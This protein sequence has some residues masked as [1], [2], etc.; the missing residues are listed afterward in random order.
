MKKKTLLLDIDEVINDLKE[1]WIDLYNKKYNDNLNYMN[2][3][4][5]E[6]DKF[7]KPEAKEDIYEL[8]KTPGLF[9]KMLTPPEDSIKV[10]ELLVQYYEIYPLS[11]CAY[12]QNIYEKIEY[13]EKYFPHI[14]IRNFISCKNK[15]LIKGDYMIDDY[16]ENLRYF[17]G[18]RILFNR[19]HNLFVNNLPDRIYRVNNWEDIL[20]Y[21]GTQNSDVL[22]YIGNEYSRR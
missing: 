13:L 17:D 18:Q 4:E 12:P 22:N 8:L 15:S 2:I 16:V 7:V 21:F 10:T 19:E 6:V 14:D 5:W 3:T 1:I 20:M 11:Y 9:S